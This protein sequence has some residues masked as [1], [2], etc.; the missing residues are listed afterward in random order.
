MEDDM[1]Y[2]K[3]IKRDN[4]FNVKLTF[5]IQLYNKN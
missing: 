4:V 1:K 2:E 5:A 3:S